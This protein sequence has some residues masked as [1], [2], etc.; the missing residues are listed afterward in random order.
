[1]QE[2]WE[3]LASNG[4]ADKEREMAFSLLGFM[5]A[6]ACIAGSPGSQQSSL[7]GAW[8]DTIEAA[9]LIT[10]STGKNA[11][12]TEKNLLLDKMHRIR[13]HSHWGIKRSL[14]QKQLRKLVKQASIMFLKRCSVYVS[15]HSS[16]WLFPSWNTGSEL[17]V[18]HIAI[19]ATTS[20]TIF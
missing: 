17:E 19:A 4:T 10:L 13:L 18:C 7:H 8:F 3:Q 14:L 9:I 6:D 16:K 2:N 12:W 20:T 11:S 5:Y 15:S 1:M